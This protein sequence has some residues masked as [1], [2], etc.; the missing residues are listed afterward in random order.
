MKRGLTDTP[1]DPSNNFSFVAF[2]PASIKDQATPLVDT[3]HYFANALGI[4]PSF[5]NSRTGTMLD[6]TSTF[7]KQ[8]YLL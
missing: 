7:E 6:K 5:S 2:L 3:I 8:Q 4:I 1:G